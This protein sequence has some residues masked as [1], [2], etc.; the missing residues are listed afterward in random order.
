MR[1]IFFQLVIITGILMILMAYKPIHYA[2]FKGCDGNFFFF[3][4]ESRK[5]KEDWFNCDND[6]LFR[7]FISST[8]PRDR[9][10]KGDFISKGVETFRRFRSFRSSSGFRPHNRV[11]GQV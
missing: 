2:V 8:S 4:K 6:E 10:A 11:G 3:S 1:T 5:F 9:F 7:G